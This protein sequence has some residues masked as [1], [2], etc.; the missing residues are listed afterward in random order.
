MAYIKSNRKQQKRP[1]KWLIQHKKWV[2]NPGEKGFM[3]TT[4]LVQCSHR[5]GDIITDSN[6]FD[7]QVQA[8]YSI[9]AV[10]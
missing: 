3:V 2:G 10:L 7:Y 4:K 6:G 8:D 1:L 5:P 9:K